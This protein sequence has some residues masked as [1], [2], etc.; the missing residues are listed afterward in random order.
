MVLKSVLGTGILAVAETLWG[1]V[2]QSRRTFSGGAYSDEW[3]PDLPGRYLPFGTKIGLLRTIFPVGN[4]HFSCSQTIAF[5]LIVQPVRM[6]FHIK[7]WDLF[8]YRP[9]YLELIILAQ[10]AEGWLKNRQVKLVIAAVFFSVDFLIPRP[11]PCLGSE[12]VSQFM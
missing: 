11:P 9:A 5:T 12:T 10:I 3:R 1:P 2:K 6:L 8:E 4:K 7:E